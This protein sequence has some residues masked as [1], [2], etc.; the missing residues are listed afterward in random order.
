MHNFGKLSDETFFT[1][2]CPWVKIK[3]IANPVV[4]VTTSAS[5]IYFLY[6][7]GKLMTINTKNLDE[8]M[9]NP[10]ISKKDIEVEVEPNHMN[11]KVESVFSGMYSKQHL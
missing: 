5:D 3:G 4:Q 11:T 8:L 9:R 1:G 10:N 7:N 6:N 2:K